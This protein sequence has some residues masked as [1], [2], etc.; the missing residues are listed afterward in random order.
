MLQQPL[1]L[2]TQSSLR[3]KGG[4]HTI[5]PRQSLWWAKII[6]CAGDVP[7]NSCHPDINRCDLHTRCGTHRRTED[8]YQ[9]YPPFLSLPFHPLPPQSNL[10]LSLWRP[11]YPAEV[12]GRGSWGVLMSGHVHSR[13]HG[14]CDVRC[15]RWAVADLPP[16]IFS[17]A[18]GGCC[19]HVSHSPRCSNGQRHGHQA[20]ARARSKG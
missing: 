1:F 11:P 7:L 13:A 3:R 2:C 16:A 8:R 15:Q 14:L 9:Q 5:T 10:Y 20:H 4:T 18:R 6:L 19:G 17:I 12:G